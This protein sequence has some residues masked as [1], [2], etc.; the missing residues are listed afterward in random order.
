MASTE[1]YL[2]YIL[3]TLKGI[4]GIYHKKMMGEYLLYK[5]GVLFGGIYDNRFLIKKTKSSDDLDLHEEI[6]YP[7]AKPMLLIDSEDLKEICEIVLN[8]YN[9]LRK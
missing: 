1:D 6:P 3:D 8:V 9:D 7:G 5:D 4:N 2:I